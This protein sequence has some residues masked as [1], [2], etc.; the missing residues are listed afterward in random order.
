MLLGGVLSAA[1]RHSGNGYVLST[2][3]KTVSQTNKPQAEPEAF[4]ARK[5]RKA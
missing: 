2:R 1:A 3:E 4:S 5:H